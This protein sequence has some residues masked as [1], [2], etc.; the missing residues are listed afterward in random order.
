MTITLIGYRGVGKSTIAPL[1]AARLGWNWADADALIEQQAGRSIAEIFATEGEPG[2]R[3]REAGVL[4]ELLSQ[5]RLVI[6]AGGGAILDPLSR[7]AIR[8]A[9]P[10]IWLTA[11]LDSIFARIHGD[12]TSA[13]RRPS[14]TGTDPR[15][16]IETL[17]A[18]RTPLYAETA[19]QTIDTEGR[20]PTA[21]VDEILLALPRAIISGSPR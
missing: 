7:Q 20:S 1:L 5:D 18:R 6:A 12:S 4:S 2:F 13:A 11:S 14:L 21:I 10:A 15:I 3:V 16:E 19:T 8:A 17:L 9:G